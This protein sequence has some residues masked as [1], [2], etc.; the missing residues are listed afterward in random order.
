[1]GGSLQ[2]NNQGQ[3]EQGACFVREREIGVG[4]REVFGGRS[5]FHSGCGSKE[6]L[7]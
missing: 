5:K 6:P 3:S 1:L 2:L 7:S 4:D